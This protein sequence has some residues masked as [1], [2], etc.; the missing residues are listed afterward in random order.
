MKS[1]D[2]RL[3]I[4]VFL[5]TDIYFLIS[6]LLAFLLISRFPQNY[7]QQF[8]VT[9]SESWDEVCVAHKLCN[10]LSK[11]KGS[12]TTFLTHQ[13]HQFLLSDVDS[14]FCRPPPPLDRDDWQA[15]SSHAA[16]LSLFSGPLHHPPQVTKMVGIPTKGLPLLESILI[17][18][19]PRK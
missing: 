2:C 7:W 6:S 13:G 14:T 18:P 4:P 8:P 9:S 10:H 15:K 19:M 5:I 12:P 17:P 1:A 3:R 16:L 11:V